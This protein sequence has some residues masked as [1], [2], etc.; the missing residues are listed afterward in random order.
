M[1]PKSPDARTSPSTPPKA[2]SGF[3][4]PDQVWWFHS[5]FD[6]PSI[7]ACLPT[8]NANKQESEDRSAI[9]SAVRGDGFKSSSTSTVFAAVRHHRVPRSLTFR[10]VPCRRCRHISPCV[11]IWRSLSFF[12]A[13]TLR[14]RFRRRSI[15]NSG[16]SI[17]LLPDCRYTS[18]SNHSSPLSGHY[19]P[20]ILRASQPP[21]RPSLAGDP[22]DHQHSIYPV[23]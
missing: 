2:M 22:S 16:V 20:A 10:A 19:D 23:Q 13:Y 1:A 21:F 5:H 6:K 14:T 12:R 9:Q 11:S 3:C 18:P 4:L 8:D 7:S 15:G 17:H